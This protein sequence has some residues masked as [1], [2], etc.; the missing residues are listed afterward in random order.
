M[1]QTNLALANV[2]L[3]G[4]AGIDDTTR[5]LRYRKLFVGTVG[6]GCVLYLVLVGSL[7]EPLIR[8]LYGGRYVEHARLLWLIG[9]IP[10]VSWLALAERSAHKAINRPDVVFRAS[11]V[12]SI[13]AIGPGVFLTYRYGIIGAI[14]SI[15]VAYAGM[16][17][18]LRRSRHLLR[19]GAP[20]R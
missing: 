5:F 9:L 12:G 17:L 3:P 19:A 6:A 8:L 16:Y 15:I 2:L 18:W 7:S 13:V 14:L 1:I 10:L 11:V 4:L 20:S